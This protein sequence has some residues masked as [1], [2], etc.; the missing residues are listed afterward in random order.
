MLNDP[1]ATVAVTVFRVAIVAVVAVK[2]VMVAFG[3]IRV[4]ILPTP[5][6]VAV[7]AIRF[8][9]VAVVTTKPP[10]VLVDAPVPIPTTPDDKRETP[11]SGVPTTEPSN[12][13]T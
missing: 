13:I 11:V 7:V 12:G 1:L 4:E 10:A 6:T 8:G 5:T 9:M 3:E 2:V